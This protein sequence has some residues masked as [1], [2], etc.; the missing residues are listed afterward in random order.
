MD[1]ELE[2]IE[3]NVLDD[4]SNDSDSFEES[5]F[6]GL[7]HG[8][9]SNPSQSERL[10][11]PH[12]QQ[13]ESKGRDHENIATNNSLMRTGESRL[14]CSPKDSDQY[15]DIEGDSEEIYPPTVHS[16]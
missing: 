6:D 8:L 12:I 1:D 16:F 14:I 9:I 15:V 13:N 11:H 4:E 10:W 7:E 5:T 3:V 2:E